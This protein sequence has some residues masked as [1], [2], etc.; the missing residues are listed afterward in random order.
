[1]K[2]KFYA[3]ID[4]AEEVIEL[5]DDYTDEQI[6]EYWQ[7]WRAGIEIGWTRID[8]ENEEL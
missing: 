6:D 5:P 4:T 2:I 3:Y 8:D 1:M 7:E